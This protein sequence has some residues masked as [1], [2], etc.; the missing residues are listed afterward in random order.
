MKRSNRSKPKFGGG[1]QI[2]VLRECISEGQQL[3]LKPIKWQEEW[4]SKLDHTP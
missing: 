4:S 1:T 3:M 2:S